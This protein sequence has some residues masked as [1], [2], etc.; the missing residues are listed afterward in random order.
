MVRHPHSASAYIS[1]L[2]SFGREKSQRRFGTGNRGRAEFVVSSQQ[3][4]TESA[5]YSERTC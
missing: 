5:Y 1:P 2:V 4:G 3:K